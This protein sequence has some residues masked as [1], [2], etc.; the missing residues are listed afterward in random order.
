MAIT[1][2]AGPIS[3]VVLALFGAV[4]WKIVLCC[5]WVNAGFSISDIS[6]LDGGISSAVYYQLSAGN[7]ALFWLQ[8]IMWYFTRI[9][10]GLAVFNLIPI[11][12]LDG[13]KVLMFFLPNKANYKLYEYQ[14]Y[15]Y[16]GFIVL[17]FSGILDVPLG[18]LQNGVFAFIN[19]LTAWVPSLMGVIL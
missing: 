11:P 13:S 10:L 19:L 2:A 15:I 5:Y 16:I 12:P 17:M 7:D 9:N 6:S 1:A 18:F 4:L 8:F 3:N 14:T